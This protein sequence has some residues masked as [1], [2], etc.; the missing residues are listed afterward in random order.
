[1]KNSVLILGGCGFIGS[2]LA[3]KFHKE[4]Y[5]VSVVDSLEAKSSADIRNIEPILKK[6]IFFQKNTI[7]F[8][9]LDKLISENDLIIDCIGFTSHHEGMKNPLLDL[10][11]N[12]LPQIHLIKKLMNSGKKIIYLG[13]R[14][15]YGKNL[16]QLPFVES[17]VCN[18]IDPQGINKLAAEHYYRI[19]SEIGNFS[20]ISLRIVNVFGENQKVS[21]DDLGLVGSFIKNAISKGELQIFDNK[22]VRQ[23]VYAPDL[24]EIIYQVHLSK[25][26]KPGFEVFNVAG[27]IMNIL[28]MAQ[29]ICEIVKDGRIAKLSELSE[30]RNIDVGSTLIDEAK[31]LNVIGKIQHTELKFALAQTVE[32]FKNRLP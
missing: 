16:T 7:N 31:L 9:E 24:A 10:E 2:H 18:P 25:K 11:H 20:C 19:Y 8:L 15:Q 17:S 13:S 29:I 4:G 1:M 27:P 30:K 12:L 32:Y 28:E 3:M 5:N 22:M 14:T 6:I 23:F 21:G 26:I